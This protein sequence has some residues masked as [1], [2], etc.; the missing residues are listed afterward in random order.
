MSR[1][2]YDEQINYTSIII[3]FS[4]QNSGK[5]EYKTVRNI[6]NYYAEQI[7]CCF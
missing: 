2:I 3:S 4:S 5:C 7:F 6:K 1:G